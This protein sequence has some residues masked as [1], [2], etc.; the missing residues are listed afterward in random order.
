MAVENCYDD[1]ID[2]AMDFQKREIAVSDQSSPTNKSKALLET[3]YWDRHQQVCQVVDH[4]S[5][6]AT[7]WVPNH[8]VD[9][10]VTESDF[11][12]RLP[13]L[14]ASTSQFHL[15]MTASSKEYCT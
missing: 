1:I 10:M 13:P 6:D 4:D 12:R 9:Q 5:T 8:E 14:A 15:P 3:V 2:R 11:Q 7:Y